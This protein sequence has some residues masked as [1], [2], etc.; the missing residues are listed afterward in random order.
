MKE[1][2]ARENHL[3]RRL[4]NQNQKKR[5]VSLGY[6]L[7]F[8]FYTSHH[9]LDKKTLVTKNHFS[10]PHKML[11]LI[12]P[13]PPPR[14]N[15]YCCSSTCTLHNTKRIQASIAVD[16]LVAQYGN[17]ADQAIPNG[18]IPVIEVDC[19]CDVCKHPMPNERMLKEHVRAMH[20]NKEICTKC[21]IPAFFFPP[22]LSA[23]TLLLHG[24]D[25]GLTIETRLALHDNNNTNTSCTCFYCGRVFHTSHQLQI[26]SWLHEGVPPHLSVMRPS[27][28]SNKGGITMEDYRNAAEMAKNYDDKYV[29]SHHPVN[30][31]HISFFNHSRFHNEL[32]SPKNDD[33]DDDASDM[34]LP[35]LPLTG[36]PLSSHKKKSN[37]KH[38]KRAKIAAYEDEEEEDSDDE[39][40]P[41]YSDEEDE[42]DE[43]DGES[44]E[45]DV[46]DGCKKKKGKK[47]EKKEKKKE[48]EKEKKKRKTRVLSERKNCGSSQGPSHNGSQGGES[49][50]EKITNVYLLA[51][52][53]ERTG[54][55]VKA[56]LMAPG[57][58]G[59][60]MP[61]K[62]MS[63]AFR[64]T[65]PEIR[66]L[67]NAW[68]VH[69]NKR[70][71]KVQESETY[72]PDSLFIHIDETGKKFAK[73]NRR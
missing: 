9:S 27:S 21:C 36:L 30:T 35:S 56:I 26:H 47:K 29:A 54:E 4:R 14:Y 45:S 63:T 65:F 64:E 33:D 6:V 66:T 23:H 31:L 44:T 1:D 42:D 70:C 72:T 19:V 50:D 24:P 13:S 68:W 48:K 2:G 39:M 41:E 59:K 5:A 12:T 40:D 53:S 11:P 28:S 60:W 43:A 38:K 25:D 57:Q 22:N 67:I 51:N 58:I 18:S 16:K 37:N 46:D 3:A 71:D 61:M 55:S 10:C 73:Y 62:E 32:Q 69:A 49:K 7:C 20:N 15:D 8:T 34:N 52:H 17:A